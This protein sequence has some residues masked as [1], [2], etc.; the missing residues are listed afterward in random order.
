MTI[1]ASFSNTSVRP[2]QTDSVSL[3]YPHDKA[4]ETPEEAKETFESKWPSSFQICSTKEGE[5]RISTI[6]ETDHDYKVE[7]PRRAS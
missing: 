7:L 6:L 4:R 5:A 3:C 1:T 2:S